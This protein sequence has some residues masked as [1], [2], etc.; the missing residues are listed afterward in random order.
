MK[1]LTALAAFL[2]LA[3]LIPLPGHACCVYNHAKHRVT[4]TL[5]CGFDCSNTWSI[6][7]GD[8]RCRYGKGDTVKV[9]FIDPENFP[10]LECDVDHVDDH[11]WVK[12]YEDKL[13][14]YSADG[15]IKRTVNCDNSVRPK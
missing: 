2:W 5:A 6:A 8:Y 9:I 12:I 11:G 13:V 10:F 7:K 4:V 14:N 1:K 3:V 15:S